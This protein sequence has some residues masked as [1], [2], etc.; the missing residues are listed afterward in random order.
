MKTAANEGILRFW[1]GFPTY[2]FRIAPHVMIVLL[3]FIL[4]Y[5]FLDFGNFRIFKEEIQVKLIRSIDTLFIK[6]FNFQYI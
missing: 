5:N 4:M 1:A 6:T 2:V 3:F